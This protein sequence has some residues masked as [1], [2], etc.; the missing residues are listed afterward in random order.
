MFCV[1]STMA[2]RVLLSWIAAFVIIHSAHAGIGEWKNYTDMKNVRS[3]ASAGSKVWAGTSGGM[4]TFNPSDSSYQKFTNSEGLSTNDVT[5]IFIDSSGDVWVGQS[6]GSIDIYS[7]QYGTWRY[8]SNIADDKTK[9][10]RVINRFYQQGDKMYFATSFGI[11]TFSISKFEFGDTHLGFSSVS[12]PNVLDVITHQNRIFAATSGGIAATKIGATNLTDPQSWEILS[13]VTTANRFAL[14]NG[15]LYVS[16][17]S[18]L[19][20]YQSGSFSVTNNITSGVRIIAAVDTALI[21]VEGQTVK[22]LTVNTVSMLSGTYSSTVTD[23]TI[24][25]DRTVFLAFTDAGIGTYN[26]AAHRWQNFYPNGPN[27]NSFYSIIVDDN[28]V[29]WS[30]SGRSNGKGFYSFNG[31]Q[32]RNYT[33]ANTPLLL[34]NDCF[35]IGVGPNNSK[36]IGTWGEGLVYVDHTGNVSKRYDY[37]DPGFIGVLRTGTSFPSYTVPGKIAVDRSGAVWVTLY[38]SVDRTKVLWK[39]NPNGLWE[40]FPGSPFGPP[41]FMH[42]VVID[43]NNTKW[44]INAVPGRAADAGSSV[45]FFNESKNL[46]T[47]SDGWGTLGTNEGATSPTVLSVAVDKTGDVWLGTGAG[48]TII[49]DP[50]NPTTRV[51]K[52]FL[53]AVRDQVVQ[54]IAVDPLNNKWLGTTQGVFVLSPDGT[55]LIDQYTVENTQGKLVDNN[56][57]SIAIDKR[58]GIAYFGTEKGLSSLKIAAVETKSSMSTIDLSPNPVYLPDQRSVEIRGLVDESTIKVLS[59]NGTVLKQFPAQGGGRAFWDCTDGEGKSVA[60]GIYI[61]VAHDRNGTEVASAKVAVIRK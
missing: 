50:N 10:N 35:A 25:S 55:Q 53:G 1:R 13:A 47:R 12:Q 9:T 32:W 45:V 24:A 56:V 49:T 31:V 33:T 29:L 36:W 22:Y 30:V 3:A 18:G 14:F 41:S 11:A 26:A 57:F 58:Q 23:G 4:F 59:I 19:L 43:Q 34:S 48:V 51:S 15:D 42:N 27:S 20:K 40:S 60:T 52:V 16:S 37:S 38:A 2:V 28:N 61:I 6:N 54:S 44:F 17:G 8:I 7:P 5:A 39:M 21:F 46:T